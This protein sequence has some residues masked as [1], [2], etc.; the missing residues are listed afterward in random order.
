[1]KFPEQYRW[2]DAP[3]GYATSEGSPFGFFR[4]PRKLKTTPVAEAPN[5]AT[6]G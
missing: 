1:M 5:R 3:H 2:K 6:D 4:I